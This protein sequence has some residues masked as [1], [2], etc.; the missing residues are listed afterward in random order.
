M[1][2]IWGQLDNP[3]VWVPVYVALLLFSI[4]HPAVLVYGDSFQM[5]DLA[6][7]ENSLPVKLHAIGT[8]FWWLGFLGVFRNLQE[9]VRKRMTA[10]LIEGGKEHA[11]QASQIA[12]IFVR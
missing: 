6:R 12:C 9:V 10:S 4:L 7:K 1:A 2:P 8:T 5:D 11:R 3:K